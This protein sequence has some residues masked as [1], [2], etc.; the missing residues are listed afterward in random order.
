MWICNEIS[1]CNRIVWTLPLS[2][3]QPICNDKRKRIVWKSPKSEDANWW[4]VRGTLLMEWGLLRDF[5]GNFSTW[6]ERY[7]F[8]MEGTRE[9]D[10][11]WELLRKVRNTYTRWLCRWWRGHLAMLDGYE[12]RF[13]KS[14]CVHLTWELWCGGGDT[15]PCKMDARWDLKSHLTCT[16][17]EKYPNRCYLFDVPRPNDEYLQDF[18]LYTFQMSS[19]MDMRG[20]LVTLDGHEVRFEKSYHVRTLY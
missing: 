16:S 1:S 4:L 20:H 7:Y 9:V 11:R 2:P 14:S 6:G 18:P 12:M 8:R 3:V 13:E 17:R 19:H 10:A 15:W 5:F